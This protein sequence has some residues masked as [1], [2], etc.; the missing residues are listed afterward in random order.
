M[1]VNEVYYLN[2]F[3]AAEL[4]NFNKLNKTSQ[5]MIEYLTLKSENQL[6]SS[7]FIT[8]IKTAI[9]SQIEYLST[10][11]NLDAVQGNAISDIKSESIGSYSYTKKEKASDIEYINGIPLAPMV[12]VYLMNTGLLY[13]G[14]KV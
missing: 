4:G 3:E 9:C 6:L 12:K 10:N 1:I 14:V 13:S 5:A 11:G 7:R 8:Q 2:E